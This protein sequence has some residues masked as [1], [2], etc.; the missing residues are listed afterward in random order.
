MEKLFAV[1]ENTNRGNSIEGVAGPQPDVL[2]GGAPEK[3]VWPTVALL[4]RK[5]S[6]PPSFWSLAV[7]SAGFTKS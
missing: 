6:L 3:G 4:Q 7:S 2:T 1:S 5:P